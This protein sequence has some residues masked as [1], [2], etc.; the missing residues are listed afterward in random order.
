MQAQ[1]EELGSAETESRGHGA[2]GYPITGLIDEEGE[3]ERQE[4][5]EALCGR[6]IGEEIT[7]DIKEM[8][9]GTDIVI[10]YGACDDI[11]VIEGAISA[12][13]SA[14]EGVTIFVNDKGLV[15]NECDGDCPYFKNVT[16][17]D[18]AIEAVWGDASYDIPWTYK[19]GIPHS[20]FGI[21]EDGEVFCRGIVFSLAD[22]KGVSAPEP[23]QVL[24]RKIPTEAG[25]YYTKVGRNDRA[26]VADV[27]LYEGLRGEDLLSEGWPVSTS[28]DF[29]GSGPIP[30]P[31]NGGLK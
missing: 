15:E 6:E 13:F 7:P 21:M 27:I 1:V 22:V 25:L 18:T 14:Y 2:K 17:R 28:T 31:A 10:I 26:R 29:W 23:W 3:M 30:E 24:T 20:T 19:T 11:M 12:D 8:I 5:A 4:V 9:A 16:E